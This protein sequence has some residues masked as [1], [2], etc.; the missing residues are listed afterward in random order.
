MCPKQFKH[1][2]PQALLWQ[3]GPSPGSTWPE[4]WC[5]VWSWSG[6]GRW[7]WDYRPAVPAARLFC[8]AS[9]SNGDWCRPGTPPGQGC[10]STR[11]EKV[12]EMWQPNPVP[13]RLICDAHNETLR[14]LSLRAT[15]WETREPGQNVKTAIHTSIKTP[16]SVRRKKEIGFIFFSEVFFLNLTKTTYEDLRL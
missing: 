2:I 12:W 8:A 15:K 14:E 16:F 1:T 5:F 3:W 11:R 13:F 10:R 9:P 4:E 7:P 6:G